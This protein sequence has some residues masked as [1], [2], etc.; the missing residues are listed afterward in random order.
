M[1]RISTTASGKAGGLYQRQS[2]AD[3]GK[4]GSLKSESDELDQGGEPLLAALNTVSNYVQS[5]SRE[6]HLHVDNTT[7]EQR[8]S[9][10]DSAT[11]Q[12]I[13]Y[14]PANELM[15]LSR[16]IAAKSNDPIK[17]LLVKSKA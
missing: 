11:G 1:S 15:D 4:N 10:V 6:V 17:G 2:S 7:G 5:I 8:V 3:N 13:R 9:I 12:T 14:V 16:H